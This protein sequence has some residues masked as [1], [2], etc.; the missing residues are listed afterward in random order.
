MIYFDS[1]NR[2]DKKPFGAVSQNTELFLHI[3]V[4]EG[5]LMQSAFLVVAKD[6]E[7]ELFIQGTGETGDSGDEHFYFTWRPDEIGLY[8]YYFLVRDGDGNT[9]QTD[10]FQ[11]TIYKRN[12]ETPAWLKGGIMYQIFPDRFAR[13]LSYLPPIINKEYVLREDWGGMPYYLPDEQ[14][15]VRN[16]DFF[17]GNLC[18][19]TEKLDYF[20][21]LGVT[22]LYLNPIFEAY[23]NHRYDTADYKKIDPMLGTEEDFVNLCR[24]AESRG[25]RMILDGV[26]NHTGSDSIYFNKSGRY[27]EVGA[28]QSKDSKYSSWYT[29]LEYPEVYE[30][31]WGIDTLP[32]VRETDPS[33]LDYIIRDENSVINH[34]LH[35]GASGYRLDVAD[36]LPDLFLEELR[37]T[38]KINDREGAV[39]GEV[40]EDA[41]NKISYGQRRKYLLG[42]QLDSVMNYPLKDA[43]I[44]YLIYEKNGLKLESLIDN[45]WENYPKPVFTALMNI[46]GTHDTPRIRTLLTES[47]AD[48][49]EARQRLFLALLIQFFLPGIPCIYYGDEWGMQGGR[50]PFNRQCFN[51]KTGDQ[52]TFR[53]YKRLI[54]FRKRIS[55]LR[56]LEYQPRYS[57][58]SFYS[59]YR[60]GERERMVI[61]VNSGS[62]DHIL[63]FTLTNQERLKDFFISGSVSF[64]TD[65]SFRIKANSGIAVYIG[66]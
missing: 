58:G 21:Q 64:E 52:E 12:F 13:S 27:P 61:A 53:F 43:L 35:C 3:K 50:D 25:I 6:K 10:R 57:E 20:L 34:W 42:D 19:I 17:G 1:K 45:L 51:E 26:F 63:D 2:N 55:G 59:F 36:E 16:H 9:E 48:E 66:S 11:I 14:G 22:V 40:W 30:A 8:F 28:Y 39:I 24:E 31:W 41:S 23:S 7:E 18:G 15:I 29:F 65:H 33:F 62:E 37:T 49:F 44:D 38:V 32:S 4:T 47:C 56:E 60:M 5:R 46:L 54:A